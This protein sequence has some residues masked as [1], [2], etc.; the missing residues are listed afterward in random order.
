M[1]FA[2]LPRY[3]R[4]LSSQPSQRVGSG[5]GSGS[6]AAHPHPATH[7]QAHQT[8]LKS[9]PLQRNSSGGGSSLPWQHQRGSTPVVVMHKGSVGMNGV[10]GTGMMNGGGGSGSSASHDRNHV[11]QS[12]PPLQINVQH[13]H[14][15]QGQVS[16][17]SQQQQLRSASRP[18][19]SMAATGSAIR[20]RA[21]SNASSYNII[22]GQALSTPPP[23]SSHG[24][25]NQTNA[26]LPP[27]SM[28]VQSIPVQLHSHQTA[29]GDGGHNSSSSGSGTSARAAWTDD[30][31]NG[32]RQ[33]SSMQKA[34]VHIT[35]DCV[36]QLM[37]CCNA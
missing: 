1:A 37:A 18:H 24:N 11:M 8:P 17:R 2:P 23:P 14:S 35:L 36:G 3:S 6:H 13:H 10:V 27:H 25:T 12:P 16:P 31:S 7:T 28:H 20:G 33:V 26:F 9:P 21:N 22:T 32:G 34:Y 29:P 5:H 4:P 19:S 15:Q 30:R